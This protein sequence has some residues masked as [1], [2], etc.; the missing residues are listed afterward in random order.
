MNRKV[1][2]ALDCMG[3]DRAPQI[4]IEGANLIALSNHN[5]FFLLFGDSK[6]ITPIIP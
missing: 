2:I 3:G 5:A 4:V 6:K 1:N